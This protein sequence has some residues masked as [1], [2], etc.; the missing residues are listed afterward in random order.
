MRYKWEM[1]N[2]S[3]RVYLEGERLHSQAKRKRVRGTLLY[4]ESSDTYGAYYSDQIRMQTFGSFESAWKYMRYV[5]D[6][7]VDPEQFPTL[8]NQ[9]VLQNALRDLKSCKA[10]YAY[11]AGKSMPGVLEQGRGYLI[12]PLTSDQKLEVGDIVLCRITGRIFLHSILKTNLEDKR[13][14][15]LIGN[16]IGGITGWTSVSEVFGKLNKQPAP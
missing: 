11:P 1:K 13:P 15:V 3:P 14:R 8:T 2:G 16:L 12:S 6:V 9:E 10:V 4:F 5:L 7:E